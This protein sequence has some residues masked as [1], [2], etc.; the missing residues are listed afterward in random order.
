[1]K[2]KISK[3]ESSYYGFTAKEPIETIGQIECGVEYGRVIAKTKF[4][5]IKGMN[6]CLLSFKT[7][8]LLELVTINTLRLTKEEL[9]QRFPSLFSDKLGCIKN[10]EVTLEVEYE[11][12]KPV[13]QP[14]R[15]IAFC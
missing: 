15:S 2:L 8:G 13:R 5:I 4:V 14:Q 10:D 11:T 3:C 12:I 7:S 6:Q 1:M 9:Y